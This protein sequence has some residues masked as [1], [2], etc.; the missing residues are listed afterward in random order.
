MAM[1]TIKQDYRM[2]P[3]NSNVFNEDQNTCEYNVTIRE[4]PFHRT[5]LFF[6]KISFILFLSTHLI[7]KKYVQI[8][9][10]R[11]SISSLVKDNSSKSVMTHSKDDA[12]CHRLVESYGYFHIT[13]S[14]TVLCNYARST[15]PVRLLRSSELNRITK[16]IEPSILAERLPTG[17]LFLAGTFHE[18]LTS[19]W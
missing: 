2:I 10:G 14:H 18:C 1:L 13:R 19:R 3:R 15:E 8:Q 6:A 11:A 12:S 4:A 7:V 16:T 5:L 9:W 17:G